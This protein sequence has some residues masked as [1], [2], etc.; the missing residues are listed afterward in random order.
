AYEDDDL[1][2]Q[3]KAYADKEKEAWKQII[4]QS[5]EDIITLVK[6][7]HKN[8]EKLSYPN[9]EPITPLPIDGFHY[10]LE[11]DGW[12]QMSKW[13]A[14]EG[15]MRPT[16]E[17][18]KQRTWTT[19]EVFAQAERFYV[20]HHYT[21]EH[22][23]TRKDRVNKLL[24]ELNYADATNDVS[25]INEMVGIQHDG[26]K[27]IFKPTGEDFIAVEAVIQRAKQYWN[28]EDA[29]V[30]QY[31]NAHDDGT[32]SRFGHLEHQRKTDDRHYVKDIEVHIKMIE[33]ATRRMSLIA[34]FGQDHGIIGKSPRFK[35][36]MM[37]MTRYS[38]T[39]E[40]A[41]LLA[42][43]TAMGAD[44][45]GMFEHLYDLG[46]GS[47][48]QDFDI[49]GRW[50][51]K[52]SGDLKDL[53]I[54]RLDLSANQL[55]TLRKI[56]LLEKDSQ[57]NWRVVGSSV[58][59]RHQTMQRHFADYSSTIAGRLKHFM[60]TLNSI[61]DGPIRSLTNDKTNKLVSKVNSATTMLTLGPRTALQNL[62]ELPNL[63]A[64]AGMSDFVKGLKFIS[65]PGNRAFVKMLSSALDHGHR[66]M[67]ETKG[68]QWYLQSPLS[69]F[70][71]S[72]LLSRE[73]GVAI[74]WVNAQ[75]AI[76]AYLDNPS[77]ASRYALD[78]VKINKKV[79][80][81][82]KTEASE[83]VD[84]EQ[85]FTEAQERILHGS[86]PVGGFQRVGAS[87][88]SNKWV[89]IIGQ[90]LQRSAVYMSQDF[91]KRYDAYSMPPWL[92]ERHPFVSLFFKYRSWGFQNHEL[93]ARRW[94]QAWR[95]GKQGN[96]TPFLNM[97][98]AAG[99]LTPLGI[100]ALG[101]AFT[102]FQALD[103][104]DPFALEILKTYTAAQSFGIAS[105]LIDAVA[106][107]GENPFRL[108]HSL[109]GQYSGPALSIT[110][111]ILAPLFTGDFKEVFEQL[112]RR[113][114][115]SRE[116]HYFGLG[117]LFEEE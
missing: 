30:R 68:E 57:E 19:A 88:A 62:S 80:D 2:A 50:K 109:R 29:S 46:S 113:L 38:H 89:D 99:V 6:A 39:P 12:V 96:W 31:I 20:P 90:E 34:Y 5:D 10:D 64:A 69:F 67:A 101:F 13:N 65:N 95:Q 25:D 117:Q 41:A 7:A 93:L 14:P 85:L 74:G 32:L 56:G 1:M 71:Q 17:T 87:P 26:E 52:K 103:D 105:I 28:N 27:Y 8:N 79:I 23:L 75:S 73:A 33:Q 115:I 83:A 102:V 84:L 21:K 78:D 16:T 59:A 104:D 77:Q 18:D 82:F 37:Q 4:R 91:L 92:A 100:G 47:P 35:A 42:M 112:S 106:H 63:I 66:Y 94:R 11:R 76:Q 43:Y 22:L 36:R 51:D 111:R 24:E 98:L 44:K 58:K 3:V 72:E 40:E 86:M 110:T 53:D 54:D 70:T 81:A 97:S 61:A 49:L 60:N 15:R 108:E 114:P 116:A 55:E 9:G 48:K 45:I 107:A